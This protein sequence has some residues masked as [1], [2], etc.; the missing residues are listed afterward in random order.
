MALSLGVS[1]ARAEPQNVASPITLTG[2]VTTAVYAQ[3]AGEAQLLLV[4]DSANDQLRTVEVRTGKEITAA[5]LDLSIGCNPQDLLV[6]GGTLYVACMDLD[7]VELVDV[8]GFGLPTPSLSSLETVDVGDGPSRLL[9][10]GN[11]ADDYLIVQNTAEKSA[12]VISLSSMNAPIAI[13]ADNSTETVGAPVNVR[14]CGADADPVN[15]GTPVGLGVGF[16]RIYAGCDDGVVSWFDPFNN[17]NFSLSAEIPPLS[18]GAL[19]AAFGRAGEHGLFLQASDGALYVIDLSEAELGGTAIAQVL[20]N[21]G[22]DNYSVAGPA[23]PRGLLTFFDAETGSRW[24]ALLGAARLDLFDVG[25]LGDV[26]YT[27]PMSRAADAQL[28]TGLSS[29]GANAVRPGFGSGNLFVPTGTA[30]INVIFAGPVPAFASSGLAISSLD[31]PGASPALPLVETCAAD[32]P[33]ADLEIPWDASASED[34]AG[35]SATLAKSPPSEASLTCDTSTVKTGTATV[36]PADI[37]DVIG[38]SEEAALYFT[39]EDAEGNPGFGQTSILLDGGRPMAPTG[40][41]GTLINGVLSLSWDVALDAGDPLDSGVRSYVVRI[42]RSSG[43]PDI[44]LDEMTETS[45]TGTLQ[46]LDPAAPILLGSETLTLSV[47]SCDNVGNASADFSTPE[48]LSVVLVGAAAN[49]GETGGCV[50]GSTDAGLLPLALMA[51]LAGF[52]LLYRRRSARR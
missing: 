31:T 10:A 49:A 32:F 11:G 38:S 27:P 28:T 15:R 34:V 44:I 23:S 4:A 19:T 5:A 33:G 26:V 46:Q 7:L 40:L 21:D 25:D 12:S 37:A 52:A 20:F 30:D 3:G 35:C 2:A 9:I 16:E 18:T 50:I 47:A 45:L 51:A 1:A 43:A 13:N 41:S 8:S 24:L 42:Q 29:I 14:L 17:M 48:V 39:L 22:S 6:S 36:N